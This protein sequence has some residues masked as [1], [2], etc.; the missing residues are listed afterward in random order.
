MKCPL[1]HKEKNSTHTHTHIKYIE[2][3]INAYLIKLIN[4]Q[5][6]NNNF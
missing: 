6:Q 1:N 4:W 2:I 3:K 5:I